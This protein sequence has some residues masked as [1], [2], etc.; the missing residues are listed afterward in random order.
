MLSEIVWN[1]HR[2]LLHV[3]RTGGLTKRDLWM[4]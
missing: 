3:V 1:M 4:G 2:R